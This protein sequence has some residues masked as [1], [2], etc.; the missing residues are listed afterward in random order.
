[1]IKTK[2]G[3]TETFLYSMVFLAVLSVALVGYFWIKN[4]YDRSKKE[5]ATIRE[6]YIDAQK[7]LI[8]RETDQVIDYVRYKI[9]QAETRLE[10]TIRNRTNDAY[11]IALNLY[12]QNRANRNPEE[13][14]KLIKDALRPIRYNNQRGYYFVTRLDGVEILFADRPE[15]EGLNLL[16]MQDTRGQFVIRDMIKIIRQSGEGYYRYT[17]TRPNET[18]KDYPKIAYIK[19]FEPFDWLIGTGEYLNDV[20]KDIQQEVLARIEN[21]KFGDDGYI[22]AGQWDGLSLVAPAKGQNMIN[23]TDV[24][25]VQIVQELINAAKS[26]GGYVSYVMPKLASFKTYNKLSY[27]TGIPEWE[28]YVGA[29][30]NIDDIET[31]ISQKRAVLQDRVRSDIYKILSILFAILLFV[32]LIVKLVSDRNKRNFELFAAFF[33]KS[34]ERIRQN[35]LCQLAF[36][37]I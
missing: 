2:Y 4:A 27:I 15:M 9:S 17:W 23:V 20:V 18:G 33:F 32:L 26:G 13:L 14:K 30:V 10:Q 29:G 37:R 3:F 21:I 22:F 11:N 5:E 12:E 25:G 36:Q 28:W 6:N 24:N 35:R 34:G 1:M 16:D 7:S 31:V 8:K 19:H